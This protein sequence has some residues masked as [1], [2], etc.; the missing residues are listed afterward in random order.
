MGLDE[1][2]ADEQAQTRA[3]DPRLAHVP[4]TMERLGDEPGPPRDADALI[5]DGRRP[6]TPRRRRRRARRSASSG[7]YFRAFPTRLREDLADPRDVDLE[8]RQV[9]R[10]GRPEPVRR[11]ERIARSPRSRATSV[12][13]VV[14]ARSRISGSAWRW[15]TSR[16][17]STSAA[18]RRRRLVDPLE[19][20]ALLL[21]LE[22]EVQQRL[23]VPADQRERRP[24]L[25]ADGRDEPLAQLLERLTALM[26]RRIASSR[27][28]VSPPACVRR[29]T[30]HADR[31]AARAPDRRLAIGDRVARF[32]PRPADSRS[33]RARRRSRS[34]GPPRMTGRSRGPA[35]RCRATARRPGLSRATRSVGVDLEDEVGGPIDD[36][37]ELVPLV[38]RAPR[39]AE[40]PRRRPRARG[41]RACA[42]AGRRR[43]AAAVARPDGDDRR[44]RL[45]AETRRAPGMAAQAR[46]APVV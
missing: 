18:S 10:G 7:A 12:A 30:R 13:K 33:R 37:A 35:L 2:P 28:A 42:T 17:W 44:G 43:R 40:R 46:T 38:V 1:P 4:G 29:S 6:A 19:V 16:T 11:P 21:R 31:G 36:R 41:G 45:I 15:V 22:L 34:P 26:S 24:Q 14:V 32:G 20:G 23:G 3:R 9:G 8:R 27:A 39:G 25:V 5:V